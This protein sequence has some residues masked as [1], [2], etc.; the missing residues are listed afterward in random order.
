MCVWGA[1]R[2]ERDRRGAGQGSSVLHYCLAGPA[3]GRKWGDDALGT[4]GR[5]GEGWQLGCHL[6]PEPLRRW[7]ARISPACSC[8]CSRQC[9]AAGTQGPEMAQSRP[10][11]ETGGAPPAATHL[12]LRWLPP[13][14]PL[15][16]LPESSP[17]PGLFIGRGEHGGRERRAAGCRGGYQGKAGVARRTGWGQVL[18]T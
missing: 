17:R 3:K 16:P 18:P 4:Q 10:S 14:L 12:L 11:S 5:G 13:S 2:K 9:Y 7:L 8:L 1:G 6:S 15:P